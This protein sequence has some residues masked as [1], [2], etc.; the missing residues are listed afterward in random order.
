MSGFVAILANDARSEI[1]EP[2][3]DSFVNAFVSL[4]A[5]EATRRLSARSHAHAVEFGRQDN[6]LLVGSRESGSWTIAAGFAH[7][8]PEGSRTELADLE[9][10]F[11]L[12]SHDAAT[13]DVTVATDPGGLFALYIARRDEKTYVSTSA[14]ALA[15][16]LRLSPDLLGLETFLRAGYHFGAATNWVGVE[17]LEPG[18]CLVFTEGGVRKEF[19]W[20]PQIDATVARM[21]FD[22]TVAH[23]VDVAS[24]TYSQL[25]ADDAERWADVTGGFDTR[26]MLLL[27]RAGG[28]RFATNTVGEPD[29]LEVR[30]ARD[31]AATAGWD[32]TRIAPPEPWADAIETLVDVSV[33]WSDAQLNVLDV[34]GMLSGHEQKSRTSPSLLVGGGGEHFRNFAW[35]QE[36][37]AA[38][39]SARVNVDNWVDMR[40]L[41]PIDLTALRRDPTSEVRADMGARM[42]K[43][44]APYSSELNTTQLDVMYMYKMTGHF[45]SYLSAAH[46]F[47][48]TEMPLYF[49]PVLMAA[50]SSNYRYRANHRLM[51]HL[52]RKLDPGIAALPTTTGGPAEPY[53]LANL[54]RFVPYYLHVG[55]RAVTKLTYATTGHALLA[56]PTEL[57]AR[58]AVGRRRL[59]GLLE[60]RGIFDPKQMRTGSLYR[61]QELSALVDRSRAGDFSGFDLLG[62][63]ATLE[64]G[65]RAVDASLA[66]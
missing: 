55:R 8:P 53:R 40:L 9:G 51:R 29:D 6:G 3:V 47:L 5:R 39:R 52:I 38:G 28:V 21:T 63:I 32:W 18:T 1:P 20:R 4:R 17:R 48:R 11:A 61:T 30:I 14:L 16:H 23:C 59:V 43:W 56:S 22:Q 45:G 31:V 42:L 24:T 19:Y 2:E 27:L 41:H 58:V 36:F 65:L 64:L 33:G 44:A 34:A 57:P 12:I 35:Q 50:V 62:R 54:Y 15:K 25:L 49:R 46:A 66:E 60:S 13:G 26:L 7:A 10:Q 37:L